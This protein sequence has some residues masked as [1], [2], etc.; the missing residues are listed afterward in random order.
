MNPL[1]IC[2]QHH[3]LYED[4]MKNSKF[5]VVPS[6]ICYHHCEEGGNLIHTLEVIDAAFALLEVSNKYGQQL[7][8]DVVFVS[9]LLHDFGKIDSYNKSLN[10]GKW[11]KVPE[12]TKSYHV[13]R[14]IFYAEQ[15]LEKR[16][17]TDDFIG[18]VL[19]CIG[20]HHGRREWGALHL[21]ESPEAYIVHLA[22]MHS[23]LVCK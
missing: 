5:C 13:E 2:S 6:S 18:S 23:A 1:H 7:D 15:M 22:D 3:E 8:K 9:C 16:G 20:S 17:Y 11:Y 19:S 12:D 4:V 14:S 10:T 21:P